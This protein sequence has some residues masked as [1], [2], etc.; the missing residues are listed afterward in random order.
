MAASYQSTNFG[1]FSWIMHRIYE[2]PSF[3]QLEKGGQSLKGPLNSLS[4]FGWR[5]ILHSLWLEGLSLNFWGTYI[6]L[7]EE[8]EMRNDGGNQQPHEDKAH[9][10]LKLFRMRK[11][12][13]KPITLY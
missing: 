4:V 1:I 13:Q 9:Q 12:D 10:T 2:Y 5:H 3:V 6:G 8:G 11:I 7:L